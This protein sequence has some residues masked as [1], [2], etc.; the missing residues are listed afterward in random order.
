MEPAIT[1]TNI[2]GAALIAQFSILVI[3]G[4]G[5]MILSTR[6]RFFF[7]N[8]GDHVNATPIIL[9]LTLISFGALFFS[10]EF[11]KIYS[12]V[13]G[14]ANLSAIKWST[15]ICAVFIAN[16][17]VVYILVAVTGGSMASPFTPVYF[18]LPALAIFLREPVGRVVVY[19]LLVIALFS[20]N[21]RHNS[22]NSEIIFRKKVAYWFVALACF[23]LTT[24]IGFITRPS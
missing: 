24:Y 16:T 11:S 4:M 1:P 7:L 14:G 17:I 13:F 8:S 19:L 5:F 23:M 6:S 10:D 22:Q 20:F 18:M 21:F 12:P 15:A 2:T 3:L 9:S